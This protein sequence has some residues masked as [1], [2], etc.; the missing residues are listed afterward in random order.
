VSEGSPPG[1]VS[2]ARAGSEPRSPAPD[3]SVV[4]CVV[5]AWVPLVTVV[6]SAGT[7]VWVGG[8]DA[9]TLA[10]PAA[11]A[12]TAGSGATGVVVG[13]VVLPLASD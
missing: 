6:V 4:G 10:G 13:A 11:V 5:G 3:V 12:P 1:P 9:V 7:A 2:G 8:C